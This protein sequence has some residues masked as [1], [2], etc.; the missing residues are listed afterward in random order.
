MSMNE[1]D[2][3]SVTERQSLLWEAALG[4]GCAIATAGAAALASYSVVQLA[5]MLSEHISRIEAT[6]AASV[7]L[8]TAAMSAPAASAAA[9]GA[10]YG[11]SRLISGKSK[12]A[13]SLGRL[14]DQVSLARRD[15]RTQGRVGQDRIIATA[16]PVKLAISMARALHHYTGGKGFLGLL[17]KTERLHAKQDPETN[18]W[19]VRHVTRKGPCHPI[20]MTIEEFATYEA[21]VEKG[22][23]PLIKEVRNGDV[24]DST[25]TVNGQPAPDALALHAR[26]VDPNGIER[27]DP[28]VF[29]RGA[30]A[31]TFTELDYHG[32][33]G[34]VSFIVTTRDADGNPSVFKIL[35][36]AK[37]RS[38][39]SKLTEAGESFKV[40]HELRPELSLDL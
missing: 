15:L 13:A 32:N 7:S 1:S 5:D 19:L 31:I 30:T 36:E 20:A 8:G 16:L 22:H 34:K 26:A 21:S 17:R 24:W 3:P 40:D 38:W 9:V 2:R 6:W 35:P 28:L 29:C 10:I 39:M 33:D 12:I 37:A 14:V 4:G 11:G 23:T 18:V 25:A 27:I